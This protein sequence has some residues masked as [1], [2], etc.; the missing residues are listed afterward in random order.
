M[1]GSIRAPVPREYS[2]E[3]WNRFKAASDKVYEAK[4]ALL[5]ELQ[6]QRRK[7]LELKTA[8]LEKVELL[9][10]SVY[11]K[12]KDW[13]DSTQTINGYFEE[14]KKV[15]PVPNEHNEEIWKKFKE[16]RNAF[17]RQKNVF[18][19]S[20]NKIKTDNLA[21]KEAI[22]EKA[23]AL[24]ESEDWVRATNELI[25]LQNDWKKIGAVP[26]K[27]S[28]DVWKRFR[29]ACD[30]F[31]GRKEEH[32]KG[33]KEEQR[34]SLEV[35]KAL[36]EQLRALNER[37]DME[38]VFRELKEIQKAWG[39]A[40]FVPFKHK[41]EIQNEFSALA[42]GI[43][44]KFR[45]NSDL[46][47]EARLKD[48]YDDMAGSDEGKKRLQAEERRIKEKIRF[49]KSDIETLENNIGFFSNSKT[50]GPL[51][52]GITEKIHKSNQQVQKL[53]KELSVIKKLLVSV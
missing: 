35:K 12:P 44:K 51:I 16:L 48:H 18:F 38:E 5:D 30:T 9:A 22:C 21:L 28:D 25:R 37:E 13:I 32:F 36:I 17:F 31:F 24:Q 50:A 49:I 34:Q 33:Q 46:M 15:G 1:S 11:Q 7:N 8:L 43:Y 4:K 14:W 39:S 47:N 52:S 19:K 27:F 40:G 23:E 53:E 2:E 45:R 6:E 26:E 42:D 10:S 41:N 20:L 29:S 3:I